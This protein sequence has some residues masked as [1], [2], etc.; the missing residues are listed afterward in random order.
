[1]A[2]WL[3]IV[4]VGALPDEEA[5]TADL[6]LLEA[7]GSTR[8]DTGLDLADGGRLGARVAIL[9]L[10]TLLLDDGAS[11]GDAGLVGV[12]GLDV[13]LDVAGEGADLVEV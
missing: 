12:D 9:E 8:S 10:S 11:V 6:A 3:I 7:E 1:M 4:V 2:V 13:G 5:T